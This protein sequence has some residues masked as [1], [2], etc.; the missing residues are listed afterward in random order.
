[1]SKFSPEDW[2]TFRMHWCNGFVTIAPEYVSVL[3]CR[4]SLSESD[5]YQIWGMYTLSGEG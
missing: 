5:D 2:H 1:M 4:L 3:L